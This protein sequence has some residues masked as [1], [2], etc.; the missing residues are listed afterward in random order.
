MSTFALVEAMGVRVIEV[1]A[2]PEPI[3]YLRAYQIALVDADLNDGAREIAA[4][5]LLASVL[6]SSTVEP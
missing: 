5:L 2:L 4:N 6:D 1:E 3:L